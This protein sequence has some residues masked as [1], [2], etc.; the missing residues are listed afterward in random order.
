MN[1]KLIIGKWENKKGWHRFFYF[2][3]AAIKEDFLKKTF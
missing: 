1:G 3:V 2:R